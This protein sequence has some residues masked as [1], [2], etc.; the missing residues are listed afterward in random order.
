MF[1]DEKL[2]EG[3]YRLLVFNAVQAQAAILK[4][5]KWCLNNHSEINSK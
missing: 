5:C 4:I 3:R 2:G 1:W